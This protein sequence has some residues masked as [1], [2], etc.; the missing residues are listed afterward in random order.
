MRY[1]A[2]HFQ[3]ESQAPPPGWK[4]HRFQTS[5]GYLWTSTPEAREL[6]REQLRRKREIWRAEA[7]GEAPHDAELSAYEAMELAAQ[8]TWRPYWLPQ[9]ARVAS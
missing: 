8:T 2:L 5:R 4:G 6:A 1:L 7:R 9:G 3:K